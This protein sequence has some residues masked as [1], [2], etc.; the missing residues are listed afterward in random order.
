[1]SL[2]IGILVS[3]RG[4]N[5]TAILKAVADGQ[6][7]AHVSVVLSN[8][9]DAPALETARRYGVPALAINHRGLSRE[10]HERQ[11]LEKLSDYEL[12]FLVLAGY[13]RILTPHFLQPFRDPSGY[14]RVINIHPSL[15][16]AFPGAHGYEDAYAAG[17]ERSG[18]TVHLV[19][20]EMDHGP[21]LMQGEFPRLPADT[22]DEFKARGLALEHEIYPAVLSKIGAGGIELALAGRPVCVQ[23]K[24]LH[25][26]RKRDP[27]STSSMETQNQ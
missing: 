11:V 26:G 25:A 22:L 21:I 14:Y 3:G 18:V 7:N 12:D 10:D 17:V 13:M 23:A 20:E 27:V 24:A 19:D 16:P 5:M 4:S 15:L 8:N 9:P 1:M 6:L 2:S